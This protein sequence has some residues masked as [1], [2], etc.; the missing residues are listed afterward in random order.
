MRTLGAMMVGRYLHRS[1][2]GR[3]GANLNRNER[4]TSSLVGLGLTALSLRRGRGKLARLLSIA[5]GAALARRGMS[6]HCPLYRSMRVSS[7]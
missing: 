6:G 4:W 7:L 3:R 1:R 5:A 2:F